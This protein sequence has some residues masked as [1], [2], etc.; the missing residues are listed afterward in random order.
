[1]KSRFSKCTQQSKI[2]QII[3]FI[4]NMQKIKMGS[5]KF[6]LLDFQ[7]K[8]KPPQLKKSI[9]KIMKEL[10][11]LYKLYIFNIYQ[12][13]LQFMKQYAKCV[14]YKLN[15]YLK[16]IKQQLKYFLKLGGQKQ[17]SRSF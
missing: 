2:R 12:K 4:G 5:K 8:H 11:L 3:M 10:K 13:N 15:N 7:S 6:E 1:M 17:N 9:Q 14:L 16:K